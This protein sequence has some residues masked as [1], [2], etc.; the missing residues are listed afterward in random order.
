MSN[1]HKAHETASNRT[2]INETLLDDEGRFHYQ[3]SGL[4]NVYLN[5]GGFKISPDGSSIAIDNVDELHDCIA[6]YLVEQ[7][8]ELSGKELRFLRKEIGLT[9]AELASKVGIEKQAVGRWEREENSNKMADRMLRV[10][11][12]SLK[13]KREMGGTMLISLL[14]SIS[15]LDDTEHKQWVFEQNTKWRKCG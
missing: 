11:Y 10:L 1:R 8:S 14:D 3:A 4:D 12:L 7:T 15:E 2:N 6:M 13:T 9:H 5:S